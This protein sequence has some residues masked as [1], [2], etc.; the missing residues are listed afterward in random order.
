MGQI[1]AK[2]KR[3]ILEPARSAI[4][5][6]GKMVRCNQRLRTIRTTGYLPNG[7]V[8]QNRGD[9]QIGYPRNQEQA[10]NGES[11]PSALQVGSSHQVGSDKW[12]NRLQSPFKYLPGSFDCS[13][14]CFD[15]IVKAVHP[16][17]QAML[18]YDPYK[19]FMETRYRMGMRI[20]ECVDVHLRLGVQSSLP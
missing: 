6:L 13:A 8:R 11:P 1:V 20:P 14:R 10:I 5:Y 17:S 16:Q 18:G 15:R 4:L 12:S 2:T 3:L 9:G 7:M 19:T